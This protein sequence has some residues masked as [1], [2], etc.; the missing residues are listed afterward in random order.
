[1]KNLDSD[2]PRGPVAKNLL[3]NSGDLSLI[4]DP[5]WSAKIP[6]AMGQLSPWTTTAELVPF[7]A[8]AQQ[9]KPRHYNEGPA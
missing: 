9:G 5:T 3:C 8:D 4:S 1:M 6:H 2:F 7:R